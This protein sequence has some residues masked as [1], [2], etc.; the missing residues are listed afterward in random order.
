[1]DVRY[2]VFVSSTFVDLKEERSAV[3]QTL[4]EMDCIPAGM[5]LFPA[6]D[7]EQWNFIK[8]IVDDC[9][10]YV[11]ILGSRYGSISDAGISYTEMEYDYAIEKGLRVLAFVHEHPEERPSKLADGDPHLKDKLDAF[12]TKVCTGRLVKFW[13]ETKELPGLVAL[14]LA[15]TVR[16]YPAIGWVRAN[17][18]TTE[19]ATREQNE[20]LKE[21]EA[22]RKQVAELTKSQVPLVEGLAPLE[23]GYDVHLTYDGWDGFDPSTE[24]VSFRFSWLQIFTQ[25][26]PDLLDHPLDASMQV[27]VGNALFAIANPQHDETVKI[28]LEDL[29][30]IRTQLTALGLIEVERAKTVGGGVG[31]FWSLTQRGHAIMM[32]ERSVRE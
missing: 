12:R 23:S 18:V 21:V 16:T 29:K 8:R 17:R 26:A 9:D 4:M 28:S 10:Y 13:N 1:M 30:T 3:F 11:L 25:I 5:E 32:Q 24:R 2:Q 19:E 31:L 20:L 7:D 14:S 15:K 6:M 22:L 27:K